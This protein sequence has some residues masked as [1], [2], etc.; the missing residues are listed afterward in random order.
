MKHRKSTMADVRRAEVASDAHRVGQE[1]SGWDVCVRCSAIE[2]AWRRDLPRCAQCGAAK[3]DPC[4][5]HRDRT[6][7][8]HKSREVAYAREGGSK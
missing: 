2:D 7:R 3:G 6:T 5:T 8:P 4:R 1:A